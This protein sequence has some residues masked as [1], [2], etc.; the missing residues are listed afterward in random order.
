M[1]TTLLMVTDKNG[2][3]KE[4]EYRASTGYF[5]SIVV[6]QWADLIICKT[7]RNSIIQQGMGNWVLNF[8]L[9][10]E[11]IVALI[12]CYMPGMKKGLR[13]YPVRW[14]C[15]LYGIP[16]GLLIVFFDEGRRYLIR[17]SPGGWVEQETY[18]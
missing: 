5:V 15:W 11:T 14:Y 18:Y 16:F 12:L 2:E 6:T 1:W 10:F 4:L 7:R 17:R 8:A 13:M 9:F 3:R